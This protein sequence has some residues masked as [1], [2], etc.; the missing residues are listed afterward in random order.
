[1]GIV[2]KRASRE[3]GILGSDVA[4]YFAQISPKEL[5]LK[6]AVKVTRVSRLA[7]GESNLNY[8]VHTNQGSYVIRINMD[9]AA[10]AKSATEFGILQSIQGWG[11]APRAFLLDESK[12]RFGDTLLVIEYIEGDPLSEVEDGAISLESAAKLARIV[13]AIH[14]MDTKR[15][16]ITLPTRGST[17]ESWFSRM[18]RDMQY[19]RRNRK[20]RSLRDDFDRLLKKSFERLRTTALKSAPANVVTVGHGDICAQNAIIDRSDGKMRLID[21]E[22]FGLWDPA[23]EVA[24]AFETFGLEFPRDAEREFLRVYGGI[25]DDETLNRRLKAFRPIVRFEQLTW[26]LRHVFEIANGEM[27]RAFV[28]A[29]DMSRHIAFVDFCLTK[30]VKTG[31]VAVD[32]DEIRELQIFPVGI[33]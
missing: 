4:K 3:G 10:S 32:L 14:R 28:E 31:I 19:V 27:N 22:N 1:V 21:W 17:Y 8:L 15:I 2:L 6:Q 11:V 18:K 25:R 13:A 5:G 9:P 30:L 26:G 16:P 7:L 29:T 20:D 24:M 33:A 23:A 12:T